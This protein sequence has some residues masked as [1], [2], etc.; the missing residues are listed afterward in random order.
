M[1]VALLLAST[2]GLLLINDAKATALTAARNTP[3]RAG[4]QVQIPMKAGCKIWAGSIVSIDGSGFATNGADAASHKVVGRAAQT[5][6]NSSGTNAQKVI[7]VD[8]GV[9]GWVNFGGVTRANIGDICYIVD[10]QT[11]SVT[12]TGDNSIICGIIVD[13]DSANSR[14]WVDTGN[15]G[16]TA[17][18]HTTLAVSGAATFGSTVVIT[19]ATTLASTLAVGDNVNVTG[20]LTTSVDI[21]SADGSFSDD[22][23]VTDDLTV[24][25]AAAVDE[26]LLVGGT[27]TASGTVSAVSSYGSSYFGISA[28]SRFQI[29]NTT[30]LVYVLSGVT[31]VIDADLAN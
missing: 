20:G 23:T 29:Q 6:D 8:R 5:V 18:S 28:T 30:Q 12:N 15:L 13:Y 3:E 21:A 14:V 16:A 19:G 22:L 24:S 2:V 31:N 25:G 7:N 1:I 27:L 11:V 4:Y 10:D 9:F 26:T 17:G